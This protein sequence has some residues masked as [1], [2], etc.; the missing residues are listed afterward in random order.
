MKI[1]RS[2]EDNK[3]KERQ[4]QDFYQRYQ[5]QIILSEVGEKGQKALLDAKVLIIGI[6]GLGCPVAQYL[7]AAGIGHLGLIDGDIVDVT[8][9]HRQIL[10]NVHDSGQKKVYAAKEK[11]LSY[12]PLIHIDTY[13]QKF[14]SKNAR[15]IVQKYDIIVD[16]TD[17]FPTR[18]LVN[19]V[20]VLEKKPYIYSS[21]FQFEGQITVFNETEESPCYRCLFPEP[22]EPNMIP[23]C[24]EAGVIGVLPGVLGLAQANEVIKMILKIGSSLSGQLSTYDALAS[25]WNNYKIKKN[26]D[27]LVCSPKPQI[28]KL[29][30]YEEFCGLKTKTS[31]IQF[32]SVEDLE[33]KILN[34]DDDF[35]LI[36]VREFHEHSFG[37]IEQSIAIPL[38]TLEESLDKIPQNKTII[39]TCQQGPRALQASETLINKGYKD[40]IILEG[41]MSAWVN[42][43]KKKAS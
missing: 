24:A 39:I 29:Q 26:E 4:D 32:I 28:T 9:L 10:F 13:D 2:A 20:C 31:N 22:P 7:A 18:Y 34:N 30:D 12:N 35:Q 6:G 5:R 1:V 42:S 27:C 14:T 21:I 43:F 25:E 17:N 16:C 23:N 3:M 36:D 41:G 11:L 33:C 40:I 37:Y 15:E 38:K 19:D 8:N